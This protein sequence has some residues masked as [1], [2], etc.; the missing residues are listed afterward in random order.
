MG[1]TRFDA[2]LIE[3]LLQPGAFSHAVD[4]VDL[5]ET[6][7]SWV[8]LA[9]DYAYKIKKPIVLD[10]L[11]FGSLDK[12]RACCEEEIRLN[13]PWAPDLY[14]DVVP[15]A[16]R[17]ARPVF[18]GDGEAVEFAVRM[19]RFDQGLRL[20]A[21]LDRGLLTPADMQQIGENIAARHTAAERSPAPQRERLVDATLFYIRE[22]FQHLAGILGRD[23]HAF[24]HDWTEDALERLRP[25]IYRRFDDGCFRDC[26]GDLH[27]GNLVRLE[28]GITTFDC[29]EF[30]PDL[31]N[32]D[33]FA[34]VAFLVMDLVERGRSDLAAHF[35]NSYLEVTGDY[36]GLAML[37]LYFVY[38][39]LVR[40]KVAAI[41]SRE[42]E[43][44]A[45]R[46]EDVR[47]AR[48]YCDMARRQAGK[49]PRMLVVMSGLSGSGKTWLS[50]QLLASLVAIRI[51]SDV[52]RKRLFGLEPS[53]TSGS[54]YG[55][56]IYSAEAGERTYTRLRELGRLVLCAG[57]HV[58]LDAAFLKRDQRAAALAVGRDAGVG[59]IL[60]RAEAPPDLLRQRVSRRS[61]SSG[62]VSEA[63]PGVLERQLEDAEPLSPQEAAGALIVDTSASV[64]ADALAGKLRRRLLKQ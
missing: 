23:E 62:E 20:D 47:V 13:Q 63:G 35:L 34:D 53:A 4:R 29:I 39:C 52:E 10:F 40:A 14:I 19:R 8:I 28:Q 21:Q 1:T 3:A 43:A 15:I 55:E 37:D 9:G 45:E 16:L 54:A 59:A 38:R 5:V 48:A 7:I 42:R 22:N 6:H 12:R 11:D 44:G 60:L 58:I 24:L 2:G 61:A 30:N 17:G 49:G 26:H 31:R 57:H 50:G 56:G 46:D 27:L 51:R 33:V 41:R 32:T 18:G 36:E 64:D 25:S